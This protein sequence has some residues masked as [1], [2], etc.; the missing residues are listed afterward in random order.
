MFDRTALGFERISPILGVLSLTATQRSPS[1]APN[2]L[3]LGNFV[4]TP[5]LARLLLD[6]AGGGG[7]G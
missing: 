5:L 7:V 4:L 1:F 2:L 6:G 3:N